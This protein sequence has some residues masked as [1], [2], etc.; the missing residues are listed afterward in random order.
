MGVSIVFY[1]AMRKIYTMADVL[2]TGFPSKIE[3][4]CDLIIPDLDA[5]LD[6]VAKI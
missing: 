4:R 2:E 3:E 5:L 6:M 1:P